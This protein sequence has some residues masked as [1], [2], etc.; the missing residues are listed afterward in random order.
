MKKNVELQIIRC[1]RSFRKKI[2]KLPRCNW[3]LPSDR[4][5]FY[6]VFVKDEINWIS[7]PQNK[8][9]ETQRSFQNSEKAEFSKV[10]SRKTDRKPKPFESSNSVFSSSLCKIQANWGPGYSNKRLVIW[11]NSRKVSIRSIS[12]FLFLKK[13][14]KNCGT[15][16]KN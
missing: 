5:E 4:S 12:K 6:L 3:K 11:Q 8:S 16:T 1:T 13:L 14:S 2:R 9:F 15:T 7:R 10:F